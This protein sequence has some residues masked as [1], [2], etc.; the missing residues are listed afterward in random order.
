MV[1]SDAEESV[2]AEYNKLITR[3]PSRTDFRHKL[4]EYYVSLGDTAN[5][6][7]VYQAIL[8]QK[9]NDAKSLFFIA[10]LQS[11]QQSGGNKVTF[12]Q[13]LLPTFQKSDVSVDQKIGQL[14]PF[15]A[16]LSNNKDADFYNALSNLTN[17]LVK[18]HPTNPKAFAAAGDVA[19]FADKITE[20][21]QYYEQA[22]KLQTNNFAVWENAL[23]LYESKKEYNNVITLA[24]NALDYFPNQ[25]SIYYLLGVSYNQLS[26][27]NEALNALKTAKLM[28]TKG[29]SALTLKVLYQ[30]AISYSGLRKYP[31]AKLVIDEAM[32]VGGDKIPEVQQ[33]KKELEQ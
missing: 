3:Y 14:Q 13:S 26:N 16:E 19:N 4:A 5:A 29:N 2:L 30:M 18:A 23:Y 27:H 25:P 22:I 31:E 33:L 12:L 8:E 9:P 1:S 6:K 24:E 15:I 32:K 10:S 17:A 7:A 28:L 20:A 21:L 11:Q